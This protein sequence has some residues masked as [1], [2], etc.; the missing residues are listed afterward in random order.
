MQKFIHLFPLQAIYLSHQVIKRGSGNEI[1]KESPTKLTRR[2][3]K[4]EH[5]QRFDTSSKEGKKV[6]EIIRLNG[7]LHPHQHYYRH[8]VQY[9]HCI[10][11]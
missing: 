2:S 11:T 1:E 5:P 4:E 8:T 9:E 6:L 10:S 3:K 7:S